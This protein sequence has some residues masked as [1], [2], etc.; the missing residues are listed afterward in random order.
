MTEPLTDL[1]IG[2]VCHGC[3]PIH[4]R[5]MLRR[6]GLRATHQRVVLGW[7]LLSRSQWQVNADMLFEQAKCS[8]VRVGRLTVY[9]TLKEFTRAGLLREIRSDDPMTDF[10]WTVRK[11][12]HVSPKDSRRWTVGP[13]P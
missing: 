8:G 4:V 2:P 11:H 3:T 1:R 13:R 5:D 10:D 7:L 9:R 12:P 6:L